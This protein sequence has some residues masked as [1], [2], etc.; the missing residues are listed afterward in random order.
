M[1]YLLA[2]RTSKWTTSRSSASCMLRC[3]QVGPTVQSR[4]NSTFVNMNQS[5]ASSAWVQWTQNHLIELH[6]W[7]HLPWFAE[8][9]L[10]TIAARTLITFP[11]TIKQRQ[12]MHRM[13]ALTPE[14]MIIAKNLKAKFR[15]E[16]FVYARS[17][18][19]SQKM[20]LKE[21]CC[22]IHE[23]YLYNLFRLFFWFVV[24]Q[25]PEATD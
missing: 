24:L 17:K 18:A 4:N 3:A 19:T 7:L 1:A 10:V 11:L 20:Y 25:T 14:L 5:I 21:V 23:C 6:E 16:E 9:A 8:I 13:E 2:R 22:T 12:I 15:E